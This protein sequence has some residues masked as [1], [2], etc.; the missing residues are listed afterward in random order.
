[1]PCED[2]TLH[3]VYLPCGPDSGPISTMNQVTNPTKPSTNGHHKP[4]SPSQ[5]NNAQTHP[6]MDHN[7][8]TVSYASDTRSNSFPKKDSAILIV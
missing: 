5:P 4:N 8:E 2:D 3:L 7:K 1:M 6:N